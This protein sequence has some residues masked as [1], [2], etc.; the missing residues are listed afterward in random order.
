MALS[1]ERMQGFAKLRRSLGVCFHRGGG[2]ILQADR[3]VPL[4]GIS[5]EIRAPADRRRYVGR[6]VVHL[7]DHGEFGLEA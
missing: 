3:V 6:D 4:P 2:G 5:E 7:S 1:A